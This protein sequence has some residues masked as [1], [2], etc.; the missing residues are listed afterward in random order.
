MSIKFFSLKKNKN[1]LISTYD[2][3]FNYY[4]SPLYLNY[5]FNS[6]VDKLARLQSKVTVNLKK[7]KNFRNFSK[8]TRNK[9]NMQDKV[10]FEK[11]NKSQKKFHIKNFVKP[12][13]F[14]DLFKA[15]H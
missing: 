15:F 1:D 9:N 14:S 8:K 6:R 12:Q 10:Y 3:I 5:F 13:K 2:N 7:K 4:N 11:N